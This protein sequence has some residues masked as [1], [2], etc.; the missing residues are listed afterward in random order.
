MY[1]V[2]STLHI[3]TKWQSNDGSEEFPS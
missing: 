3:A 2:L 1:I